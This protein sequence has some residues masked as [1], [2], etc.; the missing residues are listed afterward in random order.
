MSANEIR[1]ALYLSID[2][3][4]SQV[5]VDKAKVTDLAEATDRGRVRWGLVAVSRVSKMVPSRRT[6]FMRNGDGFG[7]SLSL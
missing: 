7:T 5:E 6:L 4:S 3:L 2:R 1:W